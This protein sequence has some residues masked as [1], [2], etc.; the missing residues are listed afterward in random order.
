MTIDQRLEE[1]GIVLPAP[2][3]VPP[4]LRLPFTFVN[5]R[6]DRATISGHPSQDAE[7]NIAGPFGRLGG[8]LTTEQGHAAARAIA[9][10]VLANLRAEIGTLDRVAGWTRVFGMVNSVPGFTE[11]HVVM[12]G[13]SD[14]IL[15]VFGPEIGR[16]SRSAMGA[17][18]MPLNFAIEIEA[19]VLLK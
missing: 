9:L 10:S 13:F 19:E 2:V 16:H 3:R 6:G 14:V 5:V 1:L 4:T 11:Q 17:A 18:G 12:N 8:E 7:G 15:E